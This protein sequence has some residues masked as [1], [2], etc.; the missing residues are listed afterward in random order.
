MQTYHISEDSMAIL[1]DASCLISGGFYELFSSVCGESFAQFTEYATQH[2]LQAKKPD[3]LNVFKKH[4]Q[5]LMPKSKVDTWAVAAALKYF[6]AINGRFSGDVKDEYDKRI[7]IV[8]KDFNSAMIA[9]PSF[10][11]RDDRK[12]LQGEYKLVDTQKELT[13]SNAEQKSMLYCLLKVIGI[14]VNDFLEAMKAGITGPRGSLRNR[15]NKEINDKIN[16]PF[17]N[18]YEAEIINL[19]VEFDNN[20]AKFVVSA[21]DGTLML[22]S[23]RSDGLKWYLNMFIDAC[24][25]EQPM[26]HIVYLFDEPGISL[27]VN[28]QRKLRELFR[29]LANPER[30]NQVVYTTHSPY[31]LDV[32]EN[33][34]ER[35]RAVVKDES[36]I[37][38][39][40][41]TAYSPD[42]SPAFQEDTLTPII[43]AL[44]MSL[45]DTFG[46][47]NNKFNIVTEGTS[48]T[49]FLRALAKWLDID[50]SGYAFIPVVGASN[51]INVCLILHGWGCKNIALFDYDK[52]GVESGGKIFSDEYEYEQD[53]HYIYIKDCSS[54]DITE[55]RYKIDSATIEDLVP[56]LQEF[57]QKFNHQEIRGKALRAKLYISALEDGSYTCPQETLDNFRQ[58][59][60]RIN[61]CAEAQK[62]EGGNP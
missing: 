15:I 49:I 18:F 50:T 45:S 44:G 36:E 30:E 8:S 7:K 61:A 39:V 47:A 60:D 55:K 35:I 27:H 43:T 41:K 25:Q 9:L 51:C 22:F 40:Y 19:N 57:L 34:I 33:G 26:H 54:E 10:F 4:I 52:A 29:V 12:N 37:S 14:S 31:M 59:F 32:A 2:P 58:L 42:I 21:K 13:D 16:T 11:Y 53:K 28:A 6:N 23:E 56:D 1:T 24:A 62:T 46:P 38:K 20:T 48:D 3:E 17:H 5:A